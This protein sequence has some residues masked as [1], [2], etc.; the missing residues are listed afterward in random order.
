MIIYHGSIRKF[1]H[2]NKE[3]VVQPFM[4]D[5]DT[6]GFWLTSD[7]QS[8]KP[9]AEGTETVIE[10]SRTEFWEDGEPKVVQIDRSLTG[11]VYKVYIDD[12]T[13]MKYEAS[14][15]KHSYEVFMDDRDVFCDYLGA[16]KRKLT[17]RDKAILLNKEEANLRFRKH[18]IKQGYDGFVIQNKKQY[19]SGVSDLY[20]IFSGDSLHIA[21]IWPLDALDNNQQVDEK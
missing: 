11:Y 19:H 7:I 5:L 14:S 3:L 15:E 17:W 21:D 18:L 12:P 2:F 20:C 1:N 16:Q 4:N 13:L 9:F 6:I 8:A 10:K